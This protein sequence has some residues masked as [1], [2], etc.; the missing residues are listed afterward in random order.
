MEASAA[1]LTKRA[2]YCGLCS[3]HCAA[4][5]AIR[6]LQA[7][8]PHPP[9]RTHPPFCFQGDVPPCARCRRRLSESLDLGHRRPYVPP[10]ARVV[11]VIEMN[12]FMSSFMFV[13]L[14]GESRAGRRSRTTSTASGGRGGR[15]GRGLPTR[16]SP[17]TTRPR[18]ASP[19]TSS[20]SSPRPASR[21]PAP[22]PP[23]R[24]RGRPAGR[25]C[26]GLCGLAAGPPAPLRTARPQQGHQ[27]TVTRRGG[28]WVGVWD[29]SAA[30]GQ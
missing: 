18:A 12:P 7:P 14:H 19:A 8:R 22:P 11:R 10:C 16:S 9:T 26:A 27:D 3:P 6:K 24:T 15:G 4:G 17:T 30:A 5:P 23:L 25:A 13:V 28:E 20:P 2:R 29:G 1:P 21:P